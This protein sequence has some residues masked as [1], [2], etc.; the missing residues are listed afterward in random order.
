MLYYVPY[1]SVLQAYS[2]VYYGAGALLLSI[3]RTYGLQRSSHNT[4]TLCRYVQ[5]LWPVLLDTHMVS[6]CIYIYITYFSYEAL[7]HLLFVKW[8]LVKAFLWT[9]SCYN[10]MS[11][12][13]TGASKKL[14]LKMQLEPLTV[15]ANRGTVTAVAYL[16][17]IGIITEVWVMSKLAWQIE[18]AMLLSVQWAYWYTHSMAIRVLVVDV[19]WKVNDIQ[20][21]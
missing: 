11:H 1:F 7:H 5:Q 6:M 13:H 9:S 3:S 12:P 8:V 20:Y 2:V 18:V 16:V 14:Q 19:H 15:A 21:R 10:T 17:W 4:H